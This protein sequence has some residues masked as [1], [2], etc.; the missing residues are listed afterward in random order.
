MSDEPKDEALERLLRDELAHDPNAEEHI[1]RNVSEAL[2]ADPAR[3]T[4]E[5]RAATFPFWLI[6]AALVALAASLGL[7]ALFLN[8]SR[9]PSEERAKGDN[10]TKPDGDARDPNLAALPI[11]DEP[12]PGEEI[13]EGYLFE[14]ADGRLEMGEH[15]PLPCQVMEAGSRII[16][17]EYAE[18]LAAFACKPV[19]NFFTWVYDGLP[20]ANAPAEAYSK[21]PR[22]LVKICGRINRAAPQDNAAAG[23]AMRNPRVIEAEFLGEEWLRCW[24]DLAATGYYPKV[25]SLQ[26]PPPERTAAQNAALAP[27]VLA[28]LTAMRKASGISDEWR[29]KL[30]GIVP[31]ARAVNLFQRGLEFEAQRWLADV[32]KKQD[33]RLEGL[34]ALGALPPSHEALKEL[35]CR[36]SSKQDFFLDRKSVV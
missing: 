9:A 21:V 11:A 30:R 13:W 4:G 20:P 35:F 16:P 29:T 7:F 1:M 25:E 10:Q 6:A 19:G 33:L 14:S 36:S 27:K 26:D 34:E 24:A 5:R 17:K 31:D 23:V 12:K 8:R 18:R 2:H 22:Y 32:N 15:C 28:A 3:G